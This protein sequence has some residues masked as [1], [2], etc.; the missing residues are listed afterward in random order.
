ML[1][2]PVTQNVRPSFMNTISLL[3]LYTLLLPLVHSAEV[4][5]FLEDADLIP[6]DTTRCYA[7]KCSDANFTTCNQ[8]LNYCHIDCTKGVTQCTPKTTE[9]VGGPGKRLYVDCVVKTHRCQ[10]GPET[11]VPTCLLLETPES[12]IMLISVIAFCIGT[13]VLYIIVYFGIL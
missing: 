9:C 11:G 13:I 6:P 7:S 10:W 5:T 12:I 8:A 3:L 4:I 1:S 2:I